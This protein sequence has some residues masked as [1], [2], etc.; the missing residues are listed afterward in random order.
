MMQ[1]MEALRFCS[2]IASHLVDIANDLLL[3]FCSVMVLRNIKKLYEIFALS[4]LAGEG[5]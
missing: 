1:E 2:P 5:N 3:C 4:N